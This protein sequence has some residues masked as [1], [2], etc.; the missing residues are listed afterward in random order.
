MATIREIADLA[1]VSRGTVDRVLNKRGHVSPQ[2]EER[3]WEIARALHYKPNK[4]GIYLAAQKKKLVLGVVLF[5]AGNPFFDLVEAGIQK[6]AAELVEYNCSVI[7]K[8]IPDGVEEQLL[9]IRELLKEGIHGLALS[10]Y[11]DKRVTDLIAEC[12]EANIPVVTLNTDIPTSKRMAYVGSNYYHAGETAG[13]LMRLLTHGEV[14]IGIVTGSPHVLCHTE[15][16]A[17]FTARISGLTRL[18]II[19]IVDNYDDDIISYD[20]TTRLLTEYP[21]INAL[22]FAAA[23][24]YGGCRAVTALG[25]EHDLTILTYDDIPTTKNYI[26]NLVISA[27]ICQ[28]PVVQ[29]SKPLDILFACLT[30]GELPQKEINYTQADIRIKENMHGSI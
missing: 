22:F 27:T 1:G 11:N 24:V 20:L 25:R 9:T 15:R 18:K 4:A 7:V 23:G 8:R 2:T 12:H 16:I 19:K 26:D 3:V 29:G 10:P 13:G 30:T 14:N 28:Q 6:K 17:G 21:Q 5:G